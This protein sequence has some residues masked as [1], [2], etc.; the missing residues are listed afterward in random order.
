MARLEEVNTTDIRAAIELGCAAMGNAFNADDGDIPYGGA[1][2]RPEA[3]LAGSFESHTPGRHLNG[4]LSAEAVAGIKL[5]EEVIEKHAKAAFFSYSQ[6][7][8]PLSRIGTYRDGKGTPCQLQD[9]DVREGFHALWALSAY[10]NSQRARALAKASIETIFEYWVPGEEWDRGRLAAALSVKFP[11]EGYQTFVQRLARSIGPLVKFYRSTEHQPALEL[12]LLLKDK[13]L[14]EF[15]FADGSFS[16]ERFGAHTHSTTCVLS[17]L[18]QLAE[19][20]EDGV[21]MER[22]KAFYDNGLW[23]L[24]D[25][26]GWSIE[27]TGADVKCR[28]GEANN[29]GDIIETALILARWGHREYYGDAE[30]DVA[31][32]FVALAIARCLLYCRARK[33]RR[34]RRPSQ[35]GAAVAGRF[36]FSG[37]L[38]ARAGGDLAVGKTS[39][40]L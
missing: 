18:A 27:V 40:R 32:P 3:F 5:D 2:V 33:S 9:H 37:A 4:L 16:S 28:R 22:V 12:A 23:A 10:R 20:T 19:L 11:T 14:R 25:Q 30:R 1:Q 31:Q 24:R 7:P 26:I 17:S 15:F 38:R 39:Y 13:A 36:W 29:T 6:A 8:L 35:C 34:N 21:L